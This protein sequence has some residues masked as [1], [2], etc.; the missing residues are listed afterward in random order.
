MVQLL[1]LRGHSP[2]R[3][4]IRPVGTLGQEAAAGRRQWW[5]PRRGRPA[6]TPQLTQF[7]VGALCSTPPRVRRALPVLSR[8]QEVKL[9]DSVL[10]VI[11]LVFILRLRGQGLGW[12]LGHGDQQRA[13]GPSP[14]ARPERGNQRSCMRPPVPQPAAVLPLLE[15]RGG[16]SPQLALETPFTAARRDPYTGPSSFRSGW[17]CSPVPCLPAQYTSHEKK[18][19]NMTTCFGGK[20]SYIWVNG[21]GR[22]HYKVK[23]DPRLQQLMM[24]NTYHSAGLSELLSALVSFAHMISQPHEQLSAF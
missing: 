5:C 6:Q 23:S 12:Q 17:S 18:S 11:L 4:R 19:D 20:R 16:A 14:L 3:K 15:A 22:R 2:L 13:Q 10:R 8:A 21:C 9:A 24:M 1:A 7:V